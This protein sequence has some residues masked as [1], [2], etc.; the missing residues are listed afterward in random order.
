MRTVEQQ[1]S[2][3][4]K[5]TKLN[6]KKKDAFLNKA[7][8]NEDFSVLDAQDWNEISGCFR[9]EYF[10]SAWFRYTEMDTFLREKT[11]DIIETHLK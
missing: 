3:L 7:M 1:K 9:T 8:K 10:E 11:Q 2:N 4:K 6:Q 5:V